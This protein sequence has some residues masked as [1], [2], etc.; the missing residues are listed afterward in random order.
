MEQEEL[1]EP[2]QQP[3]ERPYPGRL[4]AW[5]AFCRPKTWMI[6]C[7]PVI[8]SLALAWCESDGFRP[9]VAVFT[10]LIAIIMQA[11]SNMENDLGYAERNA[12]TGNRRGLPRA[13]TLGWISLPTARRAIRVMIVLALLN[14]AVLIY[15][16]GWVFAL[17]GLASVLAAY[18]Y[19]GGPKPIAYT[20]FGELLV[21]VFFGL[22][23]VCGTYYLQTGTL[24]AAA[25]LLGAGLGAIASGVLAV[26]NYRDLEHDA[27]IGRMTLA[28]TLGRP[29]FVQ[30]FSVLLALPYFTTLLTVGLS[31]SLWPCL[32][33]FASAPKAIRTFRDLP[34]HE[35]EELNAVMFSC[36]KLEGIFAILFAAGALVAGLF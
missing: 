36:V 1:T 32:I 26:N 22:T 13:T 14:T 3:A 11:T 24:S 19:M 33:V 5:M 21:L 30:L 10:L 8:A 6:A 18:C 31:P 16:G 17:V 29:R 20:P 23:A 7:A 28:V 2:A 4:G 27:S 34:R 15:F 35:H 25:V 12:E 9:V